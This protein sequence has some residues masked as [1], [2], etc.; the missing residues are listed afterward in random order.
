M[1]LQSCDFLRALFLIG[2]AVLAAVDHAMEGYLRYQQETPDP[3]CWNLAAFGS[4]VAC[5]AA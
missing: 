1:T 3:D 2:T 4:L 5:I